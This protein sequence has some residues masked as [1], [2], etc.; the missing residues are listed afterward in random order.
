MIGLWDAYPVTEGHALLATK[1]HVVNWFAATP[2]EQQELMAA[3]SIARDEIV[4]RHSPDGFN[5]GINEGPA[6]GQTIPHLH[7]HVIPR[8]SG[9]VPNPRGGVRGVIPGAADYT[10]AGDPPQSATHE[11][12][13]I[14]YGR[15]RAPHFAP[16]ITGREDPLLPHLVSEL[17][18]ARHA[19]IAVAF[20]L[21]SGVD[22][23]VEHVRDLLARGGRLRLLTGDY[24]DVTEPRALWR[25]LDL[26]GDVR[27]RVFES[28]ETSFHPK[29][30]IFRYPDGSAVAY[31]GSSNLTGPALGSGVEWNYRVVSSS[32][33]EGFNAVADSFDELF[34]DPS[35]VELNADWIRGYAARRSR[36]LPPAPA[37]GVPDEPTAPPPEPHAVQREALEALEVTRLEGNGAGLVVMATGLGKTWLSAFDSARPE[38]QRVLFVAH[39]EEILDQ[40]RATYRRIRPEATLGLYTGKEKLPEAEVVFASI[41]T[42]GRAAH[43]NRFDPA[44]FD[45]IVVDEFHH[46]AARTYRKLLDHFTPKFLLGL[47][48]TPDRTDGADLL[49]LCGENLVYRCDLF[50]GIELGLLSPFHYFGVPDEVDYENIPWR[51]S[52]FDEE[53][54]TQAVATVKRAQNALEQFQDRGGDRTLGFCVSTLHADFMASSFRDAGV[55]ANAV[56]SGGSSDPRA[57][58]LEQLRDGELDIVFAVDM[59]NEGVDLPNVDTVM[60]LRPTES[61]ILWLQQLGRGLRTAEGKSH[62]TVIDYIGNHRIF[63]TKPRTL[64]QVGPGDGEMERV[65]NAVQKGEVDLPPGCQV[66]YDLEAMEILRSILQPP[67]GGE[68]LRAFY[69]DF[70]SRHGV[71]PS[72]VEL[73]HAGYNPRATR[74]SYGSWLGFVR[75]MD[76]LSSEQK[77]LVKDASRSGT[78]GA[79][80][81]E[82]ETTPMTKSYKM[83]LLLS[84][85]NQ[86]SFP[87]SL[88]ID[89]LTRTFRHVLGR[90]AA[91]HDLDLDAL[92]DAELRQQ[93]E[94]QPIAAWVGGKGTGDHGYFAYE[95][96]VL[97]TTFDVPSTEAREEFQE[98]AREIVDWRL[99]E[100]VE[101]RKH[102]ELETE[103]IV[104]KVI[105]AS[106]RPIIKLPDRERQAGI[107]FDWT[108][109]EIDGTTY[110]AKF[111]KIAV[112]LIRSPDSDGNE[113]P[114]VLRGWFGPDVG[115]PGTS[116]HVQ[117]V[118]RGDGSFE[119]SPVGGPRSRDVALW[120]RYS[121][122]EIP[123]LWGFEFSPSR[124]NQ[125]FV[126]HNEHVFLLVTL[127]KADL[128]EEHRYED[129]FLSPDRF[130][131]Q[132]QNRTRQESGHG[133]IIRHHDEKGY[134][135]HLFV[136]PTKRLRTK[137]APFVYC[138]D[139]DFLAW[140]GEKPIT[141]QWN[142]RTPVPT[143]FRELLKVPSDS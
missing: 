106:G 56:H 107:P 41:Q 142:L 91:L 16:L 135:V 6:A 92:S 72:A 46:A 29:S 89:A 124:W 123:Q 141:V 60:M 138:G 139:L 49:A 111:A 113:L 44:A 110:E 84:L 99:A 26:E 21:P 128:V 127:E 66:T 121:R 7:V 54:L 36:T 134:T 58:S 63:L 61:S 83:I 77:T 2:S 105:Q 88:E 62:L 47:T 118:A 23:L 76:D 131:W 8:Y 9:D 64:F 20:V 126:V 85:L 33:G 116:F 136:R 70:R 80:L 114:G 109:V 30:Y 97:R 101:S 4:E 14:G 59:F 53:A 143:A 1:R 25:L 130:Q 65:L 39:R 82:L 34:R 55:R 52:R 24:L 93:I 31:V 17:D 42:L 19:D 45:Y 132:S 103:S 125:G 108:P 122:E 74:K 90:S 40:A 96:E 3:I 71:R 43:L 102:A 18:H 95:N 112:N 12:A 35:T 87:G 120:K 37:A 50:D 22:L 38:F 137:A 119:L 10:G 5:I 69:E 129:Q 13:K 78:P 133:Q 73:F 68:A 48:A 140:E 32:A 104:C 115:Q 27:L 81:S 28:R 11:V 79:L 100:Y 15:T 75:T 117:F 51:S 67:R 86:D 94:K 57:T 98:L